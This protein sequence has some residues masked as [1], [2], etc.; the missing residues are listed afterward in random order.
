MYFPVFPLKTLKQRVQTLKK[1]VRIGAFKNNSKTDRKPYK[2]VRH[3]YIS[4]CPLKQAL[5]KG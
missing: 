3:P 1:A 4:L 5:D 2:I